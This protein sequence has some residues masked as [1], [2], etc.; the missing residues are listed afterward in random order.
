MNQI[1]IPEWKTW[2]DVT[3]QSS[4]VVQEM[5]L[6]SRVFA[7]FPPFGHK[8]VLWLHPLKLRRMDVWGGERWFITFDP[9]ATCN[10]DWIYL[11]IH[12]PFFWPWRTMHYCLRCELST[13]AELL[14]LPV[15]MVTPIAVNLRRWCNQNEFCCNTSKGFQNGNSKTWL[16]SSLHLMLHLRELNIFMYE[17]KLVLPSYEMIF[18]HIA[19]VSL[20]CIYLFSVH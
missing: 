18:Q 3:A 9:K 7:F 10:L 12:S 11:F 19:S 5:F 1:L 2:R 16:L 14:V 13:G 17:T 8:S 20:S 6:F 15:A 4:K